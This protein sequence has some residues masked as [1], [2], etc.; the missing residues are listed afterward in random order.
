MAVANSLKGD[1][2]TSIAVIGDGAMSGMA[3][4]ALN[5]AGAL[6]KK[7]I[8]ILNDNNM[9]IAPP[10]GAMSDYF[11]KLWSGKT[12]HNFRDK[13]AKLAHAM[14][15]GAERTAK[16]IEEYTKGMVVG[17]TWFEELGFHYYGPIDGHDFNMLLPV[18]ENLR[19]NEDGPVLLHVVTQKGKGYAPAEAACD[20]YHGVAKFD[21]KTGIQ[22][23]SSG[24]APSYTSVFADYLTKEATKR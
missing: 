3:Y 20:K 1:D 13:V 16:K 24:G 5:N 11:T 23:K 10:V 2:A 14:G 4:E 12:Y 18:L 6:K 21:P 7:M 8:V 22:K 19:D 15:E 9:S 17:G